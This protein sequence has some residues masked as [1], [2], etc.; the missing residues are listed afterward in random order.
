MKKIILIL[1]PIFLFLNNNILADGKTRVEFPIQIQITSGGVGAGPSIGYNINDWIY[2]GAESLSTERKS[3]PLANGAEGT[4]SRKTN[5]FVAR[6]SIWD[7]SGFYLQ[8]GSGSADWSYKSSGPGTLGGGYWNGSYHDEDNS[9]KVNV[10][11]KG[12]VLFLWVVWD[13]IG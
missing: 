3:K 9:N 5:L 2:V 11:I 6:I 4:W 12:Q 13:G 7:D 10:D 1:I 8:A